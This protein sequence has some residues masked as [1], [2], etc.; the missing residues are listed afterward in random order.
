MLEL[1]VAVVRKARLS[2]TEVRAEQVVGAV[3]GRTPV[4]VDDMISTAATIA[5]D[6]A[7]LSGAGARE[8]MVIAATHGVFSGAVVDVLDRRPVDRL[9]VTDTLPDVRRRLPSADVISVAGPL[10]GALREPA[11]SRPARICR[12]AWRRAYCTTCGEHR[13]PPAT[14]IDHATAQ[15]TRC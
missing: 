14:A 12:Q 4:I 3:D 9:L 2:G 5:A 13:R 11:R 7:V 15:Q 1:P 10:A 6:A 8:R